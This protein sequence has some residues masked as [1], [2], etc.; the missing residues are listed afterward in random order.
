MQPD[1]IV[2]VGPYIEVI[3]DVEHDSVYIS[4]VVPTAVI[5]IQ[6]ENRISCFFSSEFISSNI[7]IRPLLLAARTI[8]KL[9]THRLFDINS[10]VHAVMMCIKTAQAHKLNL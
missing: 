9:Q 4:H 6:Y 3:S 7:R 1:L 8:H 10:A 5:F 2:L